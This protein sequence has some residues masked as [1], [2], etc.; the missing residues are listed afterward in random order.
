MAVFFNKRP[1][2]IQEANASLPTKTPPRLTS[3]R[4]AIP[5][6]R[7]PIAP[8]GTGFWQSLALRLSGFDQS[9]EVLLHPLARAQSAVEIRSFFSDR[10]P[11]AISLARRHPAAAHQFFLRATPG[12]EPFWQLAAIACGDATASLPALDAIDRSPPEDHPLLLEVL[13][14]IAISQPYEASHCLRRLFTRSDTESRLAILTKFTLSPHIGDR[15]SIEE[16]FVGLMARSTP[17]ERRDEIIPTLRTL[18]SASESPH[19]H[20]QFKRGWL[21]TM[22]RGWI[23]EAEELQRHT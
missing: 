18:L 10:L 21:A 3:D 8:T 13:S 16:M 19:Q 17:E 2:P 14:A 4:F 15:R 12:P 1:P 7:A 6:P 9:L 5:P 22:V 23:Q 11:A 20:A